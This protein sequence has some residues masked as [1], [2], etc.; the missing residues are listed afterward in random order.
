MYL[1]PGFFLTTWKYWFLDFGK[2]GP[3]PSS[4]QFLKGA[5]VLIK[6]SVVKRNS[7]SPLN[8]GP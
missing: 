8:N 5:S 4:L 3:I 2:K 7:I 1:C 6:R